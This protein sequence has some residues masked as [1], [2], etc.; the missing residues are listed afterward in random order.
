MRTTLEG[1]LPSGHP[2]NYQE[3]WIHCLNG[4]M[5]ILPGPLHTNHTL[6][7]PTSMLPLD[8]QQSVP[9]SC[10]NLQ[11][12]REV[13]YSHCIYTMTHMTNAINIFQHHNISWVGACSHYWYPWWPHHLK[14]LSACPPHSMG[15]IPNCI[16]RFLIPYCRRILWLSWILVA[17]LRALWWTDPH[18]Q[19]QIQQHYQ[20]ECPWV[21]STHYQLGCS[22]N[23]ILNISVQTWPFPITPVL[24]RQ[25]SVRSMDHQR[26][27][28]S[29]PGKTLR[30]RLCGHVPN[31]PEGINI[32]WGSS[33]NNIIADFT[34]LCH[35]WNLCSCGP[36]C[37]S[38]QVHG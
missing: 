34:T 21:C 5:A 4:A 38:T 28:K 6:P 37:S 25:C 29:P 1:I 12:N 10:Q 13:L 17:L 31:N 32:N 35:T 30:C 16:L 20:H 19:S 8:H 7:I 36:T 3:A 2:A 15:P 18:H 14:T 33:T 26:S 9:Q 24:H 11:K 27:Q 23:Y 22:H